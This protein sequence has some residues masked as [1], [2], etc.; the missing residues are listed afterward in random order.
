ME[1]N[2]EGATM[3]I[4]LY[5]NNYFKVEFSTMGFT[6]AGDLHPC[7]DIEGMRAVVQYAE[8]SDKTV[9]GQLISIVLKK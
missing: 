9:D 3:T 5:S 6:P 2:V 1:L 8:S 4:S 7:N